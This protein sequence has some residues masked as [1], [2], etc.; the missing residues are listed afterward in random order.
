MN[1]QGLFQGRLVART[2]L[3]HIQVINTIDKNH[4]VK[5]RPIGALILSIQAVS[6]YLY[7]CVQVLNVVIGAPRAFLFHFGHI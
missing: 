3:E 6:F 2:F 1:F 4:R 7:S 5:E